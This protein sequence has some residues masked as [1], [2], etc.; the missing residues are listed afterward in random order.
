LAVAPYLRIEA[1]ASG[2]EHAD[3]RPVARG[4]ADRLAK[5]RA[6]EAVG[7]GA[8]RDNFRAAGPKHASF[9]QVHLRP[10]CEPGWRDAA[11]HHVRGLSALALGQVD[12]HDGFAG[13]QALAVRP[14]RDVGRALDDAGLAAIDA[15]LHLRLRAA[16]DHDHVVVLA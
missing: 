10:Q 8:T 4:E 9:H 1:A 2:I 13:H 11:D 16:A 7:D 14:D 6:L 5:P 12:E 15:A 3:D